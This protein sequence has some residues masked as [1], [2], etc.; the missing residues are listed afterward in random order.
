MHS[1][2]SYGSD[3]QSLEFAMMHSQI[4][5]VP[6]DYLT[7]ECLNEK[8]YSDDK[9]NSD[10]L[11]EEKFNLVKIGA[12]KTGKKSQN[13]DKQEKNAT[14]CFEINPDY[15]ELNE[16]ES[17][18]YKNLEQNRGKEDKL[19][20]S[21]INYTKDGYLSCRVLKIYQT[22]EL[23][24]NPFELLSKFDISSIPKVLDKR[25]QNIG[26]PDYS[27]KI[28][29]DDSSNPKNTFTYRIYLSYSD[30]DLYKSIQNLEQY[31]DS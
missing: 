8:P 25:P 3:A 11:I 17:I 22:L 13:K 12:K 20:S 19:F 30:T 10:K 7:K 24:T 23:A 21:K 14:S 18:L 5:D 26:R 2:I 15:E 27:K 1:D 9:N 28:N 29:C 4:N 16:L 6:R 31:Y